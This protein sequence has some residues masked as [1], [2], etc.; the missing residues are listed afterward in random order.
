[1]MKKLFFLFLL[2]PL[3]STCQTA[4]K[5]E[6]AALN[7]PF[8]E[9]RWEVKTIFNEPIPA[10]LPE[11]PYIVF[12]TLNNYQGNLGCNLF[13]G[14]YFEQNKQKLK[15]TYSGSTKKL[16][17]H[18]DTEKSFLKAIRSEKMSYLI[19]GDTMRLFSDGSEVAKFYA[20]LPDTTNNQ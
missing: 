9:T 3:F 19:Q 7:K 16:C 11:K 12:D 8:R 10:D 14:S 6:L 17:S 2:I 13:F 4:K 1:M 20:T 18:M 5:A 15:M